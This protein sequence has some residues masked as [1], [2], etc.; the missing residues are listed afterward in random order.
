[1]N[2]VP[3][4][5]LVIYLIYLKNQKKKNNYSRNEEID[6]KV[7]N[8]IR[9]EIR[10]KCEKVIPNIIEYLKLKRKKF[11]EI[12]K[13]ILNENAINNNNT[14]VK[15]FENI[16]LKLNILKDK[17]KIQEKKLIEIHI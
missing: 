4:K 10:N 7:K 6:I 17:Y 11:E 2:L 8:I 1:M 14:I 5:F 12:E 16:I 15:K 9:K 3:M 13:T